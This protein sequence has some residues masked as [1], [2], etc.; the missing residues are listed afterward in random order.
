M[1]LSPATAASALAVVA[2]LSL[3]ACNRGNDQ[4]ATGTGGT[5]STNPPASAPMDNTGSATG[6]AGSG[7]AAS[8]ATGDATGA[9]PAPSPGTAPGTNPSE[10]DPTQRRSQ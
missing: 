4:A 6:N 3:G 10:T 7:S 8:G 2:A 1:K 9:T 5:S